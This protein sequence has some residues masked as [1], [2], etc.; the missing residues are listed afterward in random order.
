VGR[1]EHLN[2]IVTRHIIT[3]FD[4]E[5]GQAGLGRLITAKDVETSE[6]FFK[7]HFFQDPV[8]PGSLGLEAMIHG[9]QWWMIEQGL[10]EGMT[11]PRF[12]P[13]ALD[14]E[15]AWTYRGQVT[16]DKALICCD[17]EIVE[18]RRD[19]DGVLAIAEGNLWCDGLRIYHFKRFGMRVVDGAP[20]GARRP[21]DPAVTRFDPGSEA[22]IA[23]HAP[24]W[25]VPALPLMTLV[26]RAVAAVRHTDPDRVVVGA[27][28]VEVLG[29]VT[30]DG[31]VVLRAE[32]TGQGDVRTV[33]LHA[34]PEGGASRAVLS[35]T[36]TLAEAL[37]EAPDAGPPVAGDVQPDPYA[38]GHLFHGPAFQYLTRLTMGESASSAWLDAGRGSVPPGALTQGLLDATTHGIPHDDMR[39]WTP[40]VPADAACYPR[41]IRALRLY[42]LSLP[43]TG[44]VRVDARLVE[45]QAGA[46][47]IDVAVSGEDGRLLLTYTLEEVAVPKGPIGSADPADR[48]AFLRDGEAVTGV[49]LHRVDDEGRTVVNAIDVKLSNWLPGTVERVYGID[50]G[51]LDKAVARK[52]HGAR[53]LGVH[54][55]SVQLDG[56]TAT[57]AHFPLNP[58]STRVRASKGSVVCTG[59][60]R[61]D[62]TPVE[63]WWTR[64]FDMPPWT[65]EDLDYALIER[66]V[67]RVG[68]ADPT[69][70]GKL[71]GRPALFL[72]NHQTA[73]ESLLFSI[74]TGALTG[75]P[76]VTIAKAEHRHTWLGRFITHGFSHPEV[77]D[78]KVITYFDR[79]DKASLQTLI[80]EMAGEMA[81]GER[82]GM[83][84]VEGTRALHARHRTVKMSGAFID[85]ALQVGVPVVPV[86]FV[87]GLPVQPLS[88]RTEFPIGLGQQDIWF[89]APLWPEDLAQLTYKDRKQAILDGMHAMGPPLQTEVPLPGHPAQEAAVAERA[90]RTGVEAEHAV[91]AEVLLASDRRT[92][93]GTRQLVARLQ[94][95][96][97]IP[98][99]G[100]VADWR[101][102]L[103][104]RIAGEGG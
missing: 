27:Q 37:P 71:W 76:C 12:E 4:P 47:V 84:H 11:A 25:T 59:E 20:E 91:L 81:R 38:A 53:L 54:P 90:A 51:D 44:H 65:L 80:A 40:K 100:P 42:A 49:G 18:V 32:V 1:I 83:V 48:V 52:A 85:M 67:R 88:V 29:W 79:E 103:A 94:H 56:A 89:G 74:L 39:S 93:E 2:A 64:W 63:A 86:R 68:V 95:G 23:D 43:L 35:A 46:P 6:W 17:V 97:P 41:R 31:P 33:T 50:G 10:G 75:V 73:V 55:A 99:D 92:A 104:R 3:R 98:G 45:V 96:T 60:A 28:D 82:S 69:G 78:P 24:T 16:P 77:R 22:W 21:I 66:F 34:E 36:V 57:S 14:D 62:L 13:V 26:D 70:F 19:D 58:V 15:H 102:E 7:A 9:L 61:L 30:V 87:G 101:R 5:G 8:Q 72:G